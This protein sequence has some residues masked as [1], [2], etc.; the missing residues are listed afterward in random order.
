MKFA[1]LDRSS[2]SG[3]A[4]TRT[5]QLRIVHIA[6]MPGSGATYLTLGQRPG[7]VILS[8]LVEVSFI[9]SRS[10]LQSTVQWPPAHCPRPPPSC[11]SHL[12]HHLLAHYVPLS[13]ASATSVTDSHYLTPKLPPALP[14]C[15]TT[16]PTQWGP[17]PT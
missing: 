10:G 7:S 16:D 13:H 5:S 8:T 2:P 11:N 14:F 9:L 1:A 12:T 3:S 6:R 4:P 15:V 17:Q